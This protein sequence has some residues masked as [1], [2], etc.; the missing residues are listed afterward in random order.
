[1]GAN[2]SSS[3]RLLNSSWVIRLAPL[4]H[5]GCLLNKHPSDLHPSLALL[6]AFTT[7]PA[8]PPN[9]VSPRIIS[10]QAKP[11]SDAP[12]SDLLARFSDQERDHFSRLWHRLSSHMRDI[13]FDFHGPGWTPTVVCHLESVIL[14][15]ADRFAASKTDFGYCM[16]VPF[17]TDMLSHT[18][19]I[20]F[21]PYRTNQATTPRAI[22]IDDFDLAAGFLQDSN[23]P[24][25]D[26][27]ALAHSEEGR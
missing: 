7:L 25:L 22:T 11:V 12:P 19:L 9:A 16:A 20:A 1:M 14:Q 10:P 5:H 24:P 23:F 17:G 2:I 13:H 21:R 15:Y 3:L 8:P 26:L 27:S 18:Q 6:L 4:W